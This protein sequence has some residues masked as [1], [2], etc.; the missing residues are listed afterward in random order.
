MTMTT[1]IY[2]LDDRHVGPRSRFG[3]RQHSPDEKIHIERVGK[4]WKFLLGILK[5]VT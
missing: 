3:E 4:Y 5:N 1:E 2:D